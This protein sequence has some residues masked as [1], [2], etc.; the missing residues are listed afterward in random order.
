MD[1]DWQLHVITFCTPL[2]TLAITAA[3]H[4][5]IGLHHATFYVQ[6]CVYQ[7]LSDGGRKRFCDNCCNG[8]KPRNLSATE[9]VTLSTYLM[10]TDICSQQLLS[11]ASS[12]IAEIIEASTA[13]PRV[14]FHIHCNCRAAFRKSSCESLD[15]YAALRG[16]AMSFSG[17]VKRS[18]R[19]D[20]KA[21]A[22]TTKSRSKTTSELAEAGAPPPRVRFHELQVGLA[23]MKLPPCPAALPR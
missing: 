7:K 17:T 1:K 6:T 21:V 2:V 23:T 15:V 18:T 8:T 14:S 13:A 22:S 16:S 11:C 20:V 12:T 9:S 5:I 3:R 4:S 10:Q 19:V